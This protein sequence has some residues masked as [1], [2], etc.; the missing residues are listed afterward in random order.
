MGTRYPKNVN[1][2]KLI[3]TIARQQWHTFAKNFLYE[4]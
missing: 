4:R 3:C 1:L 2:F